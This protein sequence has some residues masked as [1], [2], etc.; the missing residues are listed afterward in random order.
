MLKLMSST[1]GYDLLVEARALLA[2][3]M[4]GSIVILQVNPEN[5]FLSRDATLSAGELG[6]VIKFAPESEPRAPGIYE[7][8]GY[9]AFEPDDTTSAR[10]I[11][12]GQCIKVAC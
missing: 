7:F 2:V 12:R 10:I 6:K 9:S 5:H 11:H 4:D 1:C 8:R 3:G